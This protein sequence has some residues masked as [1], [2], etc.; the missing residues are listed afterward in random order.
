M[1]LA[2]GLKFVSATP[3]WERSRKQPGR[4]FTVNRI[5]GR[6]SSTGITV[7][8]QVQAGSPTRSILDR[9]QQPAEPDRRIEVQG[10]TIP[11]F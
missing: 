3:A 1:Q 5:P 4:F 11:Q 2:D 6:N 9:F 8:P 7:I 10:V